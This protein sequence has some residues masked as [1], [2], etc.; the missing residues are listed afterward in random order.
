MNIH[1]VPKSTV[2]VDYKFHEGI[3][4]GITLNRTGHYYDI[5][6]VSITIRNVHV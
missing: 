5:M 2:L 3:L 4:R 1:L 6:Q